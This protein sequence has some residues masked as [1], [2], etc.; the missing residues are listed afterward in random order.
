MNSPWQDGCVSPSVPA[1]QRVG[2]QAMVFTIDEVRMRRSLI[3]RN[4][5]VKGR[6]HD[7]MGLL[8]VQTLEV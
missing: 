4:P 2:I 8:R 5:Q 7:D 3:R 1:L 6:G